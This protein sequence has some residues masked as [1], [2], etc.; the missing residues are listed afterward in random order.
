MGDE[1]RFYTAFELDTEVT[2]P[3]DEVVHARSRVEYLQLGPAELR[4]VGRIPFAYRG[5]FPLIAGDYRLRIVFRNRARNDYTIFETGLQ[6]P[7]WGTGRPFLGEPVL[8]YNAEPV[9]PEPKPGHQSYVVAGMELHP[10]AK[11]VYAFGESLRAHVP[12]T[13]G[14]EDHELRFRILA[15]G[16]S[17][18]PLASESVSLP[19]YRIRPVVEIRALPDLVGGRYRLQVDLVAASGDV[20]ANQVADFDVT[21]RSGVARPW[22]MYG[23]ND[24]ADPAAVLAAL[25]RQYDEQGDG[26]RAMELFRQALGQRPDLGDARVPLARIHLE[27]GDA[28]AAIRL[29]EPN[30]QE[31]SEIYDAVVVLG[32]A[33]ERVGDPARAVR[34]LEQAVRLRGAEPHVLNL[35]ASCEAE[36]GNVPAAI[37]YLERSLELLPE[38]DDVRQYLRQLKSRLR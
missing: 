19:E 35:L 13:G 18:P 10:N 25:G 31:D 26:P 27:R 7:D 11:R 1:N 22:A 15:A 2:A 4:Q 3:G 32:G 5:M 20:A 28:S 6:A 36:L 14:S 8:L 12:V 38:Q 17:G 24:F 33:Y 29:L 21:P 9:G 30:Y 16:D 34:F 37:G 23:T